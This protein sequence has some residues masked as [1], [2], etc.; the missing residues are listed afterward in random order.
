MQFVREWASTDRRSL[1]VFSE[2]VLR[3]FDTHRQTGFQSFE[4]GGILLGYVRGDHLEVLHATEPSSKDKRHRF[5]FEREKQ[6]HQEEALRLWKES[7]G[8]VRYLGEWHTHPQKSPTPS[9]MDRAEWEKLAQLRTDRRPVLTVIVG[10]QELYVAQAV[11]G[12]NRV[13]MTPV[14]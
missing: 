7:G 14:V 13:V 12:F 10:T 11:R 6:G 3:V 8:L 1:L 5:L 2:S 4:G 9:G